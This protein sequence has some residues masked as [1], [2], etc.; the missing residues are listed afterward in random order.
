MENLKFYSPILV[1]SK[2]DEAYLQKFF[3]KIV[4]VTNNNQVFSH[5][6]EEKPL[7]IFL[8]C[9]G[10]TSSG[11]EIA[12]KIREKDRDTILII[13]SDNQQN[14]K[15]FD[16]I[17]LHLSGY[18]QKPFKE[19]D[20]QKIIN[21]I[22][23][24]LKFNHEYIFQFKEG[25]SYNRRDNILFDR[26]KHEIKLTKNEMKLMTILSSTKYQYFFSELI[27]HTI[28]EEDSFYEDCSK[29]LKFLLYGLRKKLPEQTI[30]NSYKLGY[31]LACL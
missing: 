22:Y 18:I 15:L 26:E 9:D 29:R 5:Y 23:Q 13:I 7:I 31:K 25:F 2:E 11:L 6:Y 4:R 10:I 12:K 19:E 20:I 3:K 17:S 14:I 28:W 16:F 24:E 21:N 1:G 8:Y 30:I 27:E